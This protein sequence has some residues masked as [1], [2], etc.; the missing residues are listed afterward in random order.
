MKKLLIFIMCMT[1]FALAC[2]DSPK[3]NLL[4]VTG[5]HGFER[6][7]F[8][9]LFDSFSDMIYE[10]VVQPHANTLYDAQE[11]DKYDV[12]ILHARATTWKFRKESLRCFTKRRKDISQTKYIFRTDR[13]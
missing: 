8:F 7:Q 11:I 5:G 2:T 4:I 9:S 12:S 3:L 10:E 1:L 6:E 13:I